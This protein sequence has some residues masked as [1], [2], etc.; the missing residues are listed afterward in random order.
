MAGYSG[1]PLPQKLG[2]KEGARV[3][4]LHAPADFGATLGELPAGAVVTTRLGQA[5]D[6]IVAFVDTRRHLE[7]AIA[8]LEQAIFP[9]GA[10]W[11][12]RPRKAT[13]GPDD[14]SEHSVREVCL[15]RGLVD[16]KVCAIDDT[17]SG[18]KVVWRK[19]RRTA[20]R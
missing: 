16:V 6:V 5:H 19:E 20:G 12:A 8:K 15:P 10:I 4:L 1:T 14:I 9:D 17:W 2:I 13:Y 3:A 7:R 18:L 11:I